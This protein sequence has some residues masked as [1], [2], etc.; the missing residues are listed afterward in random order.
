[1]SVPPSVGNPPVGNPPV[2]NP[3]VENPSVRHSDEG[4]KAPLGLTVRVG[5]YLVAVHAIV[6]FFIWIFYLA[7]AK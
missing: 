7:G 6:G 1:M 3:P 5:I 2:A 4:T